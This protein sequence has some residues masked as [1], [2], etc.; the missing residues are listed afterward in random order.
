VSVEDKF[1]KTNAIQPPVKLNPIEKITRIG[2]NNMA[3]ITL[4]KTKKFKEFTP[5]ISSASICSVTRIV[6]ISEA[7]F[8][9]TLPAR[10]NQDRLTPLFLALLTSTQSI[11]GMILRQ[12]PLPST[13][14][15]WVPRPHRLL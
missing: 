1:D 9:P 7:M 10:I 8:E 11:K 14:V 12:L 13:K 5:I 15:G 2:K 3:A 4:G 6:P